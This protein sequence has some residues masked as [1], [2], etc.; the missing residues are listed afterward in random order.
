[1]DDISGMDWSQVGGLSKVVQKIQRAILPFKERETYMKLF[2]GKKLPRGMILHGPPGCGKTK[3]AKA[4]ANDLASARGLKPYFMEF[5]GA[6]LTDK[7]VGETSRKIREVF[8]RAQ[9]KAREGGLVLIFIDEIDSLFRSREGSE[10]EPW[11]ATDVGQFNKILDGMDPLGDVLVIAATNQKH[12]VDK[13]ILRPG[14]LGIDI[15]VPRPKTEADVREIL[16][17]YLTPDLPFA[18]KY[19]DAKTY[20]YTDHFGTGKEETVEFNGNR[21]KI[22]EHFIDV[23]IKRIFYD[24]SPK[25]MVFDDDGKESFVVNNRFKASTPEGDK[26]ILLKESL[27]GAVLENIVESA[28]ALALERYNRRKGKGVKAEVEITKKD[29]F[30]AVDEEMQRLKNSFRDSSQKSIS[31]FTR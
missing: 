10:Q 9:E 28:K 18:R 31:G 21:E 13:A 17:I 14:R 2:K 22:G 3:C 11:M 8:A 19:M 15:Y 24:G 12:L 25:T 16:R 7:Y 6:E 1:M 20:R 5:V 4:I 26:E 27:S 23:I 29:F 30:R